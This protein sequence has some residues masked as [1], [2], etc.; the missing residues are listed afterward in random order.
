V[1]NRGGKTLLLA[2]IHQRW[3]FSTGGSGLRTVP[4]GVDC[5]T[6]IRKPGKAR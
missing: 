3:W 4:N 5:R 1:K 2:D 6:G